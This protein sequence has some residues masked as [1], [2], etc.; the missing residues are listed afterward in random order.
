VIALNASRLP[1]RKGAGVRGESFLTA[2]VAE[3]AED[4]GKVGESRGKKQQEK[5]V[6]RLS[7]PPFL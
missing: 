7:F 1:L 5:D 3:D 6:G 4:N 2:E